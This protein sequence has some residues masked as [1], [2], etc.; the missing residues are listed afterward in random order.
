MLMIMSK[1]SYKPPD[2]LQLFSAPRTWCVA[3]LHRVVG[4]VE[5]TGRG[6]SYERACIEALSI[7]LRDDPDTQAQADIRAGRRWIP[8]VY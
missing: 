4:H 7:L 1:K 2:L 5:A 3:D 6:T 8:R